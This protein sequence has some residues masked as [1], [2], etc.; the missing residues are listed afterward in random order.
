MIY[1]V[2]VILLKPFNQH[3]SNLFSLNQNRF[4]SSS[5]VNVLP[6]LW[7]LMINYIRLRWKYLNSQ[8][9]PALDKSPHF[10][11]IFRFWWYSAQ[12]WV[13]LFTHI[14]SC[15][16]ER[17]LNN[18]NPIKEIVDIIYNFWWYLIFQKRLD[19]LLILLFIRF[20]YFCT[21]NPNLRRLSTNIK[22]NKSS[23]TI[24]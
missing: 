7:F 4:P 1:F 20:I 8:D 24:Q 2:S 14:L 18:W 23:P 22:Q 16:R 13:R 21:F 19:S 5:C 15:V 9:K 3:I 6:N 10:L 12:Y 11:L 17:I